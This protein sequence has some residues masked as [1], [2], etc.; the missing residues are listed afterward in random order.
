MLVVEELLSSLRT[1]RGEREHALGERD[2][3]HQEC[4]IARTE[5]DMVVDQKADVERVTAQLLKEVEG[6]RAAV[7][8]GLQ[9][10]RVV[11]EEMK[12]KILVSPHD[13][14]PEAFSLFFVMGRAER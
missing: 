5:W 8:Q 2:K 7:G 9:R 11:G 14:S 12:V 4:I 13:V 1:G 6:L 3:A 10:E